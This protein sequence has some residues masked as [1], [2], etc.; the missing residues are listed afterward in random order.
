MSISQYLILEQL[1]KKYVILEDVTFLLRWDLLVRMPNTATQARAQQISV[2]DGLAFELIKSSEI[3]KLISAAEQEPL[4]DMQYRNLMHVKK[5]NT[6]ANLISDSLQNELTA[7]AIEC[8]AIWQDAKRENNFKLWQPSL[9]RVVELTKEVASRKADFYGIKP[10]DCLVDMFDIGNTSSKIDI[11]FNEIEQY[12]TKHISS[13]A[14]NKQQI[15]PIAM[16]IDVQQEIIKEVISTLGY[17][18]QAGRMDVSSHPF[19]TRMSEDTRITTR[20]NA[21]DFLMA[22]AAAIHETG[23]AIYSQNI[24]PEIANSPIG[25]Y[26]NM[27]IHESQSLFYEKQIGNSYEFINFIC[28]IINKHSG[29]KLKSQDIY[30][31]LNSLDIN[32]IR[33]DSDEFTYPLHIIHRY[34]LEKALIDGSLKVADL[35]EAWNSEFKKLFG[36]IPPSNSL[37]CLQDPHW[38]G[39]DFG[40][41]PCYLL[42]SVLAA[43]VAQAVDKQLQLFDNEITPEKLGNVKRWLNNKVHQ[44]GGAYTSSE[45][46]KNIGASDINPKVFLQYLEKKFLLNKKDNKKAI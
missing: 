36:I 44:F 10:Y 39:G 29:M 12:L 8:E 15:I 19:C 38:G 5:L 40:Y 24:A 35:P 25:T 28:P 17:D 9:S 46:A 33:I 7:T 37:G 45:V 3:A 1:L 22:L 27:T 34:K 31:S 14:N 13:A 32:F 23:H 16:P 42:G 4:N 30:Q 41:F 18:F 26:G 11:I 6:N 21:E 2:I 20:Y 43:Q